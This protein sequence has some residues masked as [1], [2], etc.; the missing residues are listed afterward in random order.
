MESLALF[1]GEAG[2]HVR[3]EHWGLLEDGDKLSIEAGL[4]GFAFSGQFSL[5]FG[6]IVL[7]EHGDFAGGTLRGSLLKSGISDVGID[8]EGRNV[9]FGLGGD[10]VSLIDTLNGN[11]VDLVG[12]SDQEETRFELFEENNATTS[13]ATSQE[14]QNGT[15]SD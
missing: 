6:G 8:L 9:N 3:L 2:G 15:R 11:T 4:K 1:E 10:D 14:N 5:V 7:G 13:K 12:S